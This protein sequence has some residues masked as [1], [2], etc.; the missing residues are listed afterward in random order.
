MVSKRWQFQ[1]KLILNGTLA[2]CCLATTGTLAL[3][4]NLWLRIA[5]IVTANIVF[6]LLGRYLHRRYAHDM[7]RVFVMEYDDA[8]HIVQRALNSVRIPFHKR[9]ENGQI[10]YEL[11]NRGVELRLEEFPLNLP[12]DT[13]LQTV[14]ASKIT[15]TNV[16]EENRQLI[17]SLRNALDEA[18]QFVVNRREQTIMSFGD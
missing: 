3:V 9:T 14:D 4:P 2:A 17:T 10:S 8:S 15:L 7:V 5:I 18:F 1:N 13:N 6:F 12:V 11:H 16:S